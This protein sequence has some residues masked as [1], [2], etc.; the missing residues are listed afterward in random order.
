MV[1]VSWGAS[2]QPGEG[3]PQNGI[4]DARRTSGGVGTGLR[5]LRRFGGA[6]PLARGRPPGRPALTKQHPVR[7]RPGGVSFAEFQRLL[8]KVIEFENAGMRHMPGRNAR[9]Q[10]SLS[11]VR[12]V[13]GRIASR[14][15]FHYADGSARSVAGSIR[16]ARFAHLCRGRP[17]P[18]GNA[19]SRPLSHRCTPREGR[20]G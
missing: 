18:S 6:G 2:G 1:R 9:P 12:R 17:V 15:R 20:H 8:S 13:D 3:Q 7:G 16:N 11:R 5:R 14:V 4:D 10:P 19:V